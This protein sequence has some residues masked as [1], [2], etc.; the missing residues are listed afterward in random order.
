MNILT[1]TPF[2]SRKNEWN[3]Y[4][5]HTFNFQFVLLTVDIFEGDLEWQHKS[6]PASAGPTCG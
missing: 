4:L 2:Y 3:A 1:L 5:K 6:I